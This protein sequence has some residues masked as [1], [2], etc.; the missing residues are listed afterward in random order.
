LLLADNFA[1]EFPILVSSVVDPRGS[2]A[3]NEEANAAFQA[4][5]KSVETDDG[6]HVSDGTLVAFVKTGS[7][8]KDEIMAR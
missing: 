1:E 4:L 5:E 7:V 2:N 6:L 8:P 3:E